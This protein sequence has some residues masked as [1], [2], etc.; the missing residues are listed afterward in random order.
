LVVNI[1]HNGQ[2]IKSIRMTIGA[3]TYPYIPS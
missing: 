3:G 2:S 1:S